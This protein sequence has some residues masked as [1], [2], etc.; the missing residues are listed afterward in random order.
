MKRISLR[1]FSDAWHDATLT[2]DDIAAKFSLHRSSVSTVGQRLGLPPRKLGPKPKIPREPF[3]TWWQAGVASD[4]IAAALGISRNYTTVLARR[5]GLPNRPQGSRPKMTMAEYRAEHLR[6]AMAA[7]A[8]KCRVQF[9]AAE[10]VDGV[11]AY[12]CKGGRK[13]A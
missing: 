5:L 7:D 8:R 12:Q 1:A 6:Q 3:A 4:D 10:M 11:K 13:A 9:E 2:T